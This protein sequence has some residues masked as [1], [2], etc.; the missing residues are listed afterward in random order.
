M[1]M[2]DALGRRFRLV[3][4]MLVT[5]LPGS[6][7]L[8]QQGPSAPATSRPAASRPEAAPARDSLGRDTPRGTVLGFMT[9]SRAGRAEVGPQ[10]LDIRPGD[11]RAAE[12][13]RKLFIVLDR[14]LPPRLAELS[15]RPE[16]SLA[17]PL[18]PDQDV[19]GTIAV[20]DGTLDLVLVRVNRGAPSPVWLFSRQTLD[21]IP[22]VFDEINLVVLDDFLPAFLVKPRLFGVRLVSYLTLLLVTPLCF[23]LL[24]ALGLL[25]RPLIA[26]R[27]DGRAGDAPANPIPGA[28][29]L[30]L[31]AIAI[32]WLLGV[33]D[34][35]LPERMFWSGTAAAL[36]IVAVVWALL[37]LNAAAERYLHRRMRVSGH[38]EVAA[39]LRLARRVADVIAIA[40]GVLV[41]LH[42]VGVDPT[43]ALAGLGIG[44]IAVA[45]AAQ[46]TLENLIGGLSIIFDKAVRVGD[47]LKIGDTIGSVDYIGLRSTRIRTLDRT[48]VSV[49]NSQIANA[50]IE[51]L[52][53]R[54]KFWFHHFVGLRYE[55]TAAQMRSVL[56]GIRAYLA[57]HPIVDGSEPIRV[58]LVR[59]G[60]FSLDVEVFAYLRARDW[61]AFLETQQD[62]LL[63]VMGIVERSGTTIALPSQSV[64]MADVRQ[65][66]ADADRFNPSRPARLDAPRQVLGPG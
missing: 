23:R 54:D 64:Y 63:D 19:V 37:L 59:F 39:M 18:K 50:N 56:N 46:K 40:A 27:R 55:T 34:L 3:G 57:S 51:T 12:L 26:A 13:A 43:A 1:R 8:A 45:L 53:A 29:R 38:A 61:D 30:L 47:F 14:R 35:A 10:Y 49:P 2:T 25:L 33:V 16:G 22:E 32:R 21:R 60:P 15:D 48:I 24:G 11:P 7:A 42:Y 9:A 65:T 6:M 66:A 52:S 58:R 31:I 62:L 28:A 44:G 41:M 36:T 5:L 4:A 20:A 17:N